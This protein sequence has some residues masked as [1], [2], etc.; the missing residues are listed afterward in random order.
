MS[1]YG[2]NIKQN[3]KKNEAGIVM[4]YKIELECVEKTQ[5][6]TEEKKQIPKR[7]LPI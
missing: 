6:C 2:V 5:I 4:H 1:K 7:F 3:K